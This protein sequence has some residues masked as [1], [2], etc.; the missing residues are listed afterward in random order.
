M[1]S[2][3]VAGSVPYSLAP[4]IEIRI[5]PTIT[6][7]RDLPGTQAEPESS[8]PRKQFADANSRN[9]GQLAATATSRART[10]DPNPL[11]IPTEPSVLTLEQAAARLN[12]SVKKLRRLCRE[13]K[14]SHRRIDYR[15][16]RFWPQDL[17]EFERSKTF[18]R[19]GAFRA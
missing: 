7:Y 12:V 10:I 4:T 5:Q 14:I 16:Y 6:V 3:V 9:F 2:L 8:P 18:K 1:S 11:N 15:T 13:Q 19:K 17:A